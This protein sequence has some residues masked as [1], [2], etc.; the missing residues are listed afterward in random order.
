M[1]VE[2]HACMRIAVGGGGNTIAPRHRDGPDV[3]RHLELAVPQVF[4]PDPIGR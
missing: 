3:G 4:L 2:A 1:A